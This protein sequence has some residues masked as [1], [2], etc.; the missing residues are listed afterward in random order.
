MPCRSR[1]LRTMLYRMGSMRST[2]SITSVL[3][4]RTASSSLLVKR[5]SCIVTVSSAA[6]SCLAV[7]ALSHRHACVEGSMMSG[8]CTDCRITTAFSMDSSSPGRPSAF[9]VSISDSLDMNRRRSKRSTP[10][11]EVHCAMVSCRWSSGS[12]GRYAMKPAASS[13][14]RG[15]ARSVPSSRVTCSSQRSFSPPSLPSSR[16]AASSWLCARCRLSLSDSAS[17]VRRP[18]SALSSTTCASS[19]SRS[20]SHC[21]TRA[22]EVARLAVSASRSASS[23]AIF[24]NTRLYL[25]LA[26]THAAS[27]A[28]ATETR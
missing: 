11:N 23:G 20:A 4:K 7:C 13:E 21:P 9:H 1:S 6:L 26:F 16:S 19:A 22:R 27:G 12:A 28:A 25:T 3:P 24:S 8:A 5:L 15:S 10:K 17:P 14:S 2:S 18:N